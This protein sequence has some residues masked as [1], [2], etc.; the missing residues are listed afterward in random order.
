MVV[1]FKMQYEEIRKREIA[2]TER[3]EAVG[4]WIAVGLLL[5]FWTAGEL[6]KA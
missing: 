2:K 5:A 1:N 6:I 3:M 4:I